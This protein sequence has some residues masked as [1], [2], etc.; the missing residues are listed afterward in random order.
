MVVLSTALLL[1]ACATRPPNNVEDLCAI[2][3]HDTDWYE[4]ALDASERWQVP[5]H[6]LMAIMHQESRFRAKA[7]PE[8][9]RLLW[10][11]PWTRPSSAYGYAQAIDEVWQEYQEETGNWGGSRDVFEDAI[12]FVGWYVY[13]A[14]RVLG[15]S[16]WDARNQYLA[17]HEGLGGFRRKTYENKAWLVGVAKKVNLRAARFNQQL[18]LCKTALDDEVSG[19]WFF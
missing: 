10:I 9:T 14:H 6:V 13:R 16:K 1:T 15:L 8:R 19:W 11:I 3:W 12:D 7:R 4:H 17:Y 5:M 2:F 18:S